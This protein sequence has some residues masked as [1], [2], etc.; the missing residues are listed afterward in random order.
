MTRTQRSASPAP[1]LTRPQQVR[2]QD[3]GCQARASPHRAAVPPRAVDLTSLVP[4]KYFVMGS[5]LHHSFL[6]PVRPIR[7]QNSPELESQL[8]D[9]FR[10]S[11]LLYQRWDGTTSHSGGDH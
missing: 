3:T 5:N 4:D 2:A 8:P 6:L 1:M 11:F 9:L 10:F 7:F